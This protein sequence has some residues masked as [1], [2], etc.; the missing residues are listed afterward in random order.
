MRLGS[1]KGKWLVAVLATGMIGALVATACGSEY[2]A[3]DEEDNQPVTTKVEI[4]DALDDGV[5]SVGADGVPYGIY[6]GGLFGGVEL[7]NQVASGAAL[8]NDAQIQTRALYRFNV[9]DWPG[10]VDV[11]FTTQCVTAYGTPGDLEVYLVS[12]FGSLPAT[13]GTPS[14]ISA[15]W[16]SGTKVT[17]LTPTSG[18]SVTVQIPADTVAASKSA[19]GYLAL[20]LKATGETTP[21]ASFMA[22]NTY[23]LGCHEH[24]ASAGVDKPSVQW[25]V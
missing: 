21:A 20:M 11:T 10:G 24:A 18:G 17:T 7:V 22:P 9:A 3:K 5:A 19:D 1:M 15:L 2:Q 16:N 12:D 8:Y 4:A 6:M 14:D 25:T 13:Q 23:L